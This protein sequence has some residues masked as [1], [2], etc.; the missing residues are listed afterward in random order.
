MAV[1]IHGLASAAPLN[2]VATTST[3][4]DLVKAI[5]GD[6]AEVS[7]IAPP[8][9]NV[10]FIEPKPSDVMKVK[11]ADAFAHAGLD[12]ELWSAPLR[13][14][15]G[16][17]AVMKGGA[18]DLD[19]SRGVPL[20]EVPDRTVS[21]AEGDI[22]LFGNPHYWQ[23]PSNGR[24][25]AGTIAQKLSE[26]D[27]AHAADYAKNLAV[28]QAKL[29]A[30]V[31]EWQAKLAPYKGQE[32]IGYHNEWPY[33]MQFLGLTMGQFLEP[34]P[35]IPPGPKQLEALTEYAKSGKV[36]GIVQTVYYSDKAAKTLSKATGLGIVTLSQNVGDVPDAKDYLAMFDYNVAQLAALFG[37]GK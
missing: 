29:D 10:H 5:G 6:Y 19:L 11:K 25:I 33:L 21:R 31:S 20:L 8:K 28:F 2:V 22:H 3:F 13:D 15:A 26:L 23:S 4:A 37:G 9:F 1:A 17:R 12:L 7:Y 30:K 18:G 35:G 32:L 24:I 27:A 14:A 36:Q 16:N 34:K